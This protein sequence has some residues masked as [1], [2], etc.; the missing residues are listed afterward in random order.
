MSADASLDRLCAILDLRQ[1]QEDMNEPHV[2]V[3][4]D[5]A[6]HGPDC[7]ASGVLGPFP[8]LPSA[9]LAALQWAAHL[10][11]GLGDDVSVEERLV[12][13]AVRLYPPERDAA[14]GADPAAGRATPG[15]DP[16]RSE[17]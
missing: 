6:I 12:V 1:A 16:G 15:A 11:H 8:D 5:P 9:A 17:P 3:A 7:C 4:Y 10:N 14:A 2:L 13:Q